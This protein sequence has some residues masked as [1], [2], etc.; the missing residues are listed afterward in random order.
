MPEINEDRLANE[1]ITSWMTIK[2]LKCGYPVRSGGDVMSL[3]YAIE[4]TEIV[5]VTRD[6][7]KIAILVYAIKSFIDEFALF[8]DEII[9]SAIKIALALQSAAQN[10]IAEIRGESHL[11]ILTN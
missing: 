7:N 5:I 3:L 4:Q 1:M 9:Q 2:L 6:I 10:T 8:Q 11:E